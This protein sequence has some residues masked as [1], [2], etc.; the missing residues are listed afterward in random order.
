MLVCVA[1][2]RSGSGISAYIMSAG[3]YRRVLLIVA[4]GGVLLALGVIVWINIYNRR[5]LNG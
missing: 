4:L 2:D 1:Y 3:T 5:K